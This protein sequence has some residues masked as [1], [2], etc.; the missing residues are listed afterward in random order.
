[1]LVK[2]VS[3]KKSLKSKPMKNRFQLFSIIFMFSLLCCSAT[4]AQASSSELE[5]ALGFSET[6]DDVTE[7]PIHLLIPIALAIGVVLGIKKLK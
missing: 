3:P 7:A 4:F 1:M 6:V 5:S 2:I